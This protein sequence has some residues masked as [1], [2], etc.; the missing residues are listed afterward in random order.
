MPQYSRALIWTAAIM[1]V[2]V[3][4]IFDLLPRDLAST[5]I[6]VLPALMIATTPRHEL[7]CARRG[8]A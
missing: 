2:A 4:R 6:I 1:A 8:A 5:L 7:G 3:A